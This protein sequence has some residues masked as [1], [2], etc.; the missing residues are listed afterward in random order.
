MVEEILD[1]IRKNCEILPRSQPS[2]FAAERRSYFIQLGTE[3]IGKY[4]LKDLIDP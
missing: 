3:L 4:V 2:L 1:L